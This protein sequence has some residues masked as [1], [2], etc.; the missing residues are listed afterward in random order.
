MA[1]LL[2]LTHLGSLLS[3][4][5][6]ENRVTE[7]GSGVGKK[8]RSRPRCP[9]PLPIVEQPSLDAG[10]K[11]G[12]ISSQHARSLRAGSGPGGLVWS[13]MSSPVSARAHFSWLSMLQP[14]RM[15]FTSS[16]SPCSFYPRD[17]ALAIPCAWNAFRFPSLPENSQ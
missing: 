5:D 10:Q 13:L 16:K 15:L 14:Q 3:K 12:S 11:S 8:G 4:A 6:P 1:E 7:V 17:F 9:E 2:P